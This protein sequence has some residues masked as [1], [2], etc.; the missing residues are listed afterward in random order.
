MATIGT[1]RNGPT[2]GRRKCTGTR[3]IRRTGTGITA[4]SVALRMMEKMG[5]GKGLAVAG[6]EG[7]GQRR[8]ML[9]WPTMIVTAPTAWK[10]RWTRTSR[11]RRL[12]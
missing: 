5:K 10:F 6:S 12:H 1:G 9:R 3:S 8:N 2:K 7:I 4:R 11:F